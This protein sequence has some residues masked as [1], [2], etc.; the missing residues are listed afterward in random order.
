M[1]SEFK[2]QVAVIGVGC[3]KFGEL[4]EAS[5]EQL[6]CDAAFEAMA[7]A[8]VEPAQIE[9]A[10][11][12]TVMSQLAGD[13]LGDPLKLQGIPITRISM[14]CASGMD[15]FPTPRWRSPRASTTSRW[16]SASRR[17]ATAATTGRIAC[18]R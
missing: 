10:W 2:N 14:Y 11:V 15:A 16:C 13:A 3:T 17:C 8:K 5:A 1:P 9:A 12:G 4:Y 18:I 7:D 6:I